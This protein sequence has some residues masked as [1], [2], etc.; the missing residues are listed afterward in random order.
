M[1]DIRIAGVG[2]QQVAVDRLG[3]GQAAGAVMRPACV[4]RRV[5][6]HASRHASHSCLRRSGRRGVEHL[7]RQ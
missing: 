3:F 6:R 2:G 7:R 5:S 4:K 1:Q